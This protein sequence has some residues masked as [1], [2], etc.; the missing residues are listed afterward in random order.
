MEPDVEA[1][2]ST[3]ETGDHVATSREQTEPSIP[4]DADNGLRSVEE[5]SETPPAASSRTRTSSEQVT[6]SSASSSTSSGS[7]SS[8]EVN[9]N[10]ALYEFAAELRAEKPPGEPWYM[11]MTR[12]RRLY[13]LYLNRQLAQ[14][15]KRILERREVSDDEMNEL[16]VLLRDQGTN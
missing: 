11:E 5:A 16:K 2:R 6:S 8:G 14:C 12:L 15:R 13:F 10:A 3:A 1:Q 9:E 4:V 7:G